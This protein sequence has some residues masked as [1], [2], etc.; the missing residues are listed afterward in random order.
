MEVGITMNVQKDF[1]SP[2][3]AEI[4]REVERETQANYEK[5]VA[6]PSRPEAK[7]ETP[8]DVARKAYQAALA[9]QNRMTS[10]IPDQ[11]RKA[12]NE[13]VR[14]TKE[15]FILLAEAKIGRALCPAE[16]MHIRDHLAFMAR[17]RAD[18]SHGEESSMFRTFIDYVENT[19][20]SDLRIG[21]PTRPSQVWFR[22]FRV[23]LL[24]FDAVMRHIWQINKARKEMDNEIASLNERIAKLERKNEI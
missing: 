20:K 24:G 11:Q 14:Q 3:E 8:I 16:R 12:V 4:V 23:M 17:L 10:N 5:A 21:V 19:L 2:T 13:H 18:K 7:A 6:E 9:E 15:E 22:S 1:H